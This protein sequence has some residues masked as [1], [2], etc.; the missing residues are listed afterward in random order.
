MST[1]PLL[2]YLLSMISCDIMNHKKNLV[3][4][5][6]N[7]AGTVLK[8]SFFDFMF[9]HLRTMDFLLNYR[10]FEGSLLPVIRFSLEKISVTDKHNY[11]K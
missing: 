10:D 9:I 3:T 8:T 1:K 4:N 11:V 2:S 5:C 7:Y 6:M